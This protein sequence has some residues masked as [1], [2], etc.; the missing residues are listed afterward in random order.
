VNVDGSKISDSEHAAA[1]RTPSCLW[2]NAASGGAFI[3]RSSRHG[4]CQRG[5]A[6]R[7]GTQND[8]HG[9]PVRHEH[10]GAGHVLDAV[11]ILLIAEREWNVALN[12]KLG[13]LPKSAG[14]REERK[15]LLGNR[16]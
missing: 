15:D 14:F 3:K 5:E 10:I 4:G 12:G 6:H 9:R 7:T 16:G 11:L 1:R 13:W 2:V 8:F